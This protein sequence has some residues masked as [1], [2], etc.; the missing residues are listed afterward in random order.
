MNASLTL[1]VTDTSTH[2]PVGGLRVQ[3]YWVEPAGDVLLRAASTNDSGT[4]AS[5]LVSG[6]K[7]S[8]GLYK[9]V[10]HAGDWLAGAH[11]DWPRHVDLVPV[12]VIVEDVAVGRRVEVT[13]SA[14]GYAVR[15]V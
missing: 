1:H 4:T 2:R 8:A 11:P 9:L 12:V 5:P 15:C 7:L 10:L 6:A 3:A 13:L 14:D